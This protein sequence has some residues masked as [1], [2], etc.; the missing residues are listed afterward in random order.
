MKVRNIKRA[1]AKAVG[2]AAIAAST[3][4]ANALVVDFYNGSSL[5]ATMTTSNATD[6][7]LDFSSS[8]YS[9]SFI[10]YINLAGPTGL[11]T[12]NSVDTV[13]SA[14]YSAGGFTDAGSQYNWQIQFPNA[15]NATRFT[16]GEQALWS[17]VVTDP[18]GW[19]FNLLH[20]N[21]MDA[22]GNSIKLS[23][24]VRG[25]PGCGDPNTP[26]PSVPEPAMLGLLGLGLAGIAAARRRR[27]A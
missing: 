19:D 7:Q 21:A 10:D 4:A 24:C 18:N 9:T 15:N 8:A 13:A 26:P 27:A 22:A 2:V 23:S 12:D 16:P 1:I 6:F 5:W 25:E 11:F 20:V 17:I 3:S 14:S